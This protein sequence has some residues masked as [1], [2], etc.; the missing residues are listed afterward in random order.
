MNRIIFDSQVGRFLPTWYRKIADYNAITDAETVQMQ[1]A[2]ALTRR[3]Y[4]NF[5]FSSMDATALKEWESIYGILAAPT[6]SLEFRRNRL[7]SRI[8]T[9]PPFNLG[10]LRRQLDTLIGAGKYNI[11]VDGANYTMYV[12][13]SA[14][15]QAYAIEVGVMVNK[16]KP[17]HI[18]YINTPLVSEG[19]DVTETISK[20]DIIYHYKLGSW[21]LGLNPF[22]SLDTPEV[23]KLAGTP[24]IQDQMLDDLADAAKTLVSKARIN[25]SIVI[26]TLTKSITDSTLTVEY[27]VG[28]GDTNQVNKIELLDSSNNVLTSTDVY[29]PITD[30]TD[31][32]HTIL[33]EEGE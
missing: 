22:R 13:S 5:Y 25:G 4:G 2:E 26:S 29:I 15:N 18:V 19:I 8:S 30:T 1:I 20:Q 9:K 21:G 6:D 28:T 32:K 31:I 17:A 24:S 23:I 3:V 10:F 33:I 27:E 16:I 11:I 12:E 14:E 7:L